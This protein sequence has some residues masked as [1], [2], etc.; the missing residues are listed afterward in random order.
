MEIK[1]YPPSAGLNEKI[2]A[3]LLGTRKSN[4]E[5]KTK[6]IRCKNQKGNN[7]P[8][9]PRRD[10]T[11]HPH[12]RLFRLYL[13]GVSV[14]GPLHLFAQRV[15]GALSDLQPDEHVQYDDD[16]HRDE[17]KQQRAQL[18]N[19]HALRHVLVQ[20]RAERALVHRISGPLNI[21]VHVQTILHTN[22]VRKTY[23]PKSPRPR[24]VSNECR[25]I[26]KKKKTVKIVGELLEF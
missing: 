24:R 17:E 7:A 2:A 10:I 1:N 25:Y 14:H 9:R 19:R 13:F 22:T 23:R 4:G 20:H 18:V 3:I 12:D 16:H 21:N 6:K 5:K 26:R 15:P 11:Q 8:V